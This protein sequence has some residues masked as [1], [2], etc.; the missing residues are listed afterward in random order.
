MMSAFPTVRSDESKTR[1]DKKIKLEEAN[2]SPVGR[3]IAGGT[4]NCICPPVFIGPTDVV[5]RTGL[6][7]HYSSLTLVR[8]IRYLIKVVTKVE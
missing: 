6:T 1:T 7:A 4:M 3:L 8:S 2:N 5:S